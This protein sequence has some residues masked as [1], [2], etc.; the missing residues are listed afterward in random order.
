MD[1]DNTNNQD[2]VS[3]EVVEEVVETTEDYTGSD[4]DANLEITEDQ[5]NEILE[6]EETPKKPGFFAELKNQAVC[7]LLFLFAAIGFI[8]PFFTVSCDGETYNAYSTTGIATFN[9][10]AYNLGEYGEMFANRQF[11]TIA[12]FA[13]VVIGLILVVLLKGEA[14]NI[15]GLVCSIGA[16]ACLGVFTFMLPTLLDD[17]VS[18]FLVKLGKELTKAYGTTINLTDP[19]TMK[20]MGIDTSALKAVPTTG[21]YFVLALLVINFIYFLCMVIG[22]S[23]RK[24]NV[25]VTLSEGELP[26]GFDEA[27]YEEFAGIEEIDN[28]DEE[29]DAKSDEEVEIAEEKTEE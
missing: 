2:N 28:A 21:L 9:K 10:M 23:K 12:A 29:A 13:I 3:E 20:Q 1:L 19:A 8:F 15:V 27:E 6:L 18:K 7:K 22:A 16:T 14:R 11:I 17:T 26:A 5:Y 4:E 24:A 25:D